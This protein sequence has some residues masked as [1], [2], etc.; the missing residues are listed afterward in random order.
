MGYCL[1]RSGKIHHKER[2]HHSL[3]FGPGLHKKKG[4]NLAEPQH[5]SIHPCFLTVDAMWPA[6]SSFC[7]QDFPKMTARVL[8]V[9]ADISC[10]CQGIL[11]RP[12]EEKLHRASAPRAV[13]GGPKEACGYGR[14]SDNPW[15]F[16]SRQLRQSIASPGVFGVALNYFNSVRPF[17]LGAAN[18]PAIGLQPLPTQCCRADLC[19]HI[20]ACG[21]GM[22]PGL[23]SGIREVE[24]WARQW[25]RDA[26][27]AVCWCLERLLIF[28]LG[29][30]KLHSE[31]YLWDFCIWGI[32]ILVLV[33]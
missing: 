9:G 18:F 30:A 21:V 22:W 16:H 26:S 4:K 31:C 13:W 19:F 14:E 29:F 32:F 3:G 6:A 5:S 1:N 10:F 2:W 12:Q 7:H 15:C 24:S 28:T 8:K 11:S 23:K 20:C 17:C 25:T 27:L 33:S